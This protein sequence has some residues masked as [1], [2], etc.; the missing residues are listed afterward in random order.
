MMVQYLR[1]LS[2][3]QTRAVHAACN[4]MRPSETNPIFGP[5]STSV[6]ASDFVLQDLE[7]KQVK[8]SDYRGKIVLINFWASWCSVC[9]SEKPSLEFFQDEFGEDIEIL[10]LASNRDW[11][12]VRRALFGFEVASATEVLLR[13]EVYGVRDAD[14]L[15]AKGKQVVVSRIDTGR[16]ATKAG[17]RRLDHIVSVNGTVINS[18]D[19]L[20]NL[21]RKP[22]DLSIV[23]GRK[24]GQRTINLHEKNSLRVLLDPPT[25]KGNLGGV[26]KSYGITAVPESFVVDKAGNIRHYFI[27]RRNW[28]GDIAGTCL[29]SL[30]DE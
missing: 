8:L 11:A 3:A 29:Q 22:G 9:R 27:N 6:E 23:V 15:P 5:M 4:G 30:I 13:P 16:T 18:L 21:L 2:P 26:A 20:N 19:D 14:S 10:A 1:L 7:G 17:L 12:P 28:D 24:D 25:D